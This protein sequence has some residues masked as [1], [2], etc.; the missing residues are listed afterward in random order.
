VLKTRILTALVLLAGLLPAMFLAPVWI[1]GLVS[2]LFLAQGAREWAALLGAPAKGLPLALFLLVAG[3]G[4]MLYRGADPGAPVP[5]AALFICAATLAVWAVFAPGVLR[6][7]GPVGPA[8]AMAALSLAACW[9]AL[10]ELRA[11][12]ALTLLSAMALVWVAD[13]GAYA[14][15]RMLGRHRLAPRVSPGK[16]W[17]GALAG[18]LSVLALAWGVWHGVSAEPL[19]WSS[20][21][22]SRLGLLWGALGLI[23]LVAL[24]IVG[25]LFESALKRAAGFKDSSQVL[26]G[27]GGVLD[28]IDALIP[29]MPAA[30]LLLLVLR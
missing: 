6:R 9:L 10:Y 17:E 2:L 4:W 26:P 20:F 29:T 22:L 24:S 12:S 18:A 28:R 30:L 25:D 1:W 16:T 27:H 14:G 21:V 11:V 8:W 19:V 15:G 3:L 23:A 13:I 7:V 5:R